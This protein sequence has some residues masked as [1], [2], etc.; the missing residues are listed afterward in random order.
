MGSQVGV[1][2]AQMG[3]GDVFVSGSSSIGRFNE[4]LGEDFG[5]LNVTNATTGNVTR[6]HLGY[7]PSR[8]TETARLGLCSAP[9]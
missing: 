1:G 9:S 3:V 5:Y 6:V 7:G 4:S 2:G 8:Q